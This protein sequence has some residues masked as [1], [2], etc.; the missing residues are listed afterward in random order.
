MGQSA[1]PR[2]EALMG[3]QRLGKGTRSAEQFAPIAFG[4]GEVGPSHDGRWLLHRNRRIQWL[5]TG[6][7]LKETGLH[8]SK[9]ASTADT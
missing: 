3:Q 2:V 5:H 4:R 7:G 9:N 8:A 6:A 1:L